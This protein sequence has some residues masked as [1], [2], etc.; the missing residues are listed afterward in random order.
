MCYLGEENAERYRKS[1]CQ[2]AR[3]KISRGEGMQRPKNRS[4]LAQGPSTAEPGAQSKAANE[5]AAH[6]S[7]ASSPARPAD[8]CGG[9]GPDEPSLPSRLITLWGR[10]RGLLNVITAVA[11]VYLLMHLYRSPWLG[12]SLCYVCGMQSEGELPC[13]AASQVLPVPST[14]AS[15][16]SC[17]QGH[18]SPPLCSAMLAT[19]YFPA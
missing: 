15:S 7:G 9:G 3:C 5:R 18:R 19:Y 14:P 4:S 11:V 6:T 17:P 12:A 8:L 13:P 16:R 10:L 1:R 2:N